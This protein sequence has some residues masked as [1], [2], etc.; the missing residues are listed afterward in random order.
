[1]IPQG[2]VEMTQNPTVDAGA[3]VAR[4]KKA[5][6]GAGEVL[7]TLPEPMVRHLGKVFHEAKPLAIAI[8]ATVNKDS[9]ESLAMQFRVPVRWVLRLR[10]SCLRA[11]RQR[12]VELWAPPK[13]PENGPTPQ[14]TPP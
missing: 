12:E 3:V 6:A 10:D 13:K 4:V 9:P 8:L 7:A 14:Q 2:R 11:L 5:H 1:M